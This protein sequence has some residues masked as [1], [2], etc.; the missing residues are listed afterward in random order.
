[1]K[2]IRMWFNIEMKISKGL[3][4]KLRLLLLLT[5]ASNFVVAQ[6]MRESKL[7]YSRQQTVFLDS[8]VNKLD[9]LL[10]L[11]KG[12]PVV[13]DLWATWCPACL[14]SFDHYKNLLP[15][16]KERNVVVVFVSFDSD[17]VKWRDFITINK[18]A[19]VHLIA[20][21]SLKD[22]L[23]TFVWGA[24]DVFSLPNVIYFDESH[25]VVARSVSD[26]SRSIMEHKK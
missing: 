20:S 10:Q 24:K 7:L 22:E 14:K 2:C 23:T 16:L 5:V 19:G 12:F 6:E 13:I 4:L 1:M 25:N 11:A 18:V 8:S 3:I 26:L 21:K 17:E 9:D 15:A